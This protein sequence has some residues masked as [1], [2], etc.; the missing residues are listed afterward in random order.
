MMLDN[1]EYSL[2][3]INTDL[4][5][6]GL[7]IMQFTTHMLHVNCKPWWQLVTGHCLALILD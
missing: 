4:R 3:S 5:E 7:P 1:I 2:L 6:V